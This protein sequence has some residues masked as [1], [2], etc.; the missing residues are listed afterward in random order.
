MELVRAPW[1]LLRE[2]EATDIYADWDWAHVTMPSK[3]PYPTLRTSDIPT[4]FPGELRVKWHS[5][6]FPQIGTFLVHTVTDAG[7]DDKETVTNFKADANGQMI[8]CSAMRPIVGEIYQQTPSDRR[9]IAGCRLE[10]VA[11][12]ALAVYSR[13]VSTDP[14]HPF[15]MA[16]TDIV[17]AWT[18]SGDY[19]NVRREDGLNLSKWNMMVLRNPYAM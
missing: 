2:G 19:P 6:A 10:A 15:H 1:K 18:W 8:L 3:V 13:L 7:D 14:S 16:G 5:L 17:N 4:R 9:L 12:E 11:L